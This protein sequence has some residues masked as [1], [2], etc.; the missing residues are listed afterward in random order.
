MLVKPLPLMSSQHLPLLLGSTHTDQVHQKEALACTMSGDC[1]GHVWK[2]LHLW[3]FCPPPPPTHTHSTCDE[4]CLAAQCTAAGI[5]P[6]HFKFIKY[7]YNLYKLRGGGKK[8]SERHHPPTLKSSLRASR[9]CYYYFQGG[10]G[11]KVM[12]YQS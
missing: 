7:N 8:Q 6:T 4:L 5:M 11:K 10:L 9:I 12:R 3:S 1:L 2:Y